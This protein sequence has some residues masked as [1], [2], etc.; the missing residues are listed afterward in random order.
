VS[1]GTVEV[2]QSFGTVEQASL[3]DFMTEYEIP[4]AAVAAALNL[5][6]DEVWDGI[7]A[8]E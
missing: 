2:D 3:D 1:F 4:D 5:N 6:L 8:I 7:L